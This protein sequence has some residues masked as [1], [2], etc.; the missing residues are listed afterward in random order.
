MLTFLSPTI[1]KSWLKS[2]FPLPHS[3]PLFSCS[4][5]LEI[6]V[7]KEWQPSCVYFMQVFS[8]SFW[9]CN[10]LKK[11]M[12][13]L[14]NKYIF[15]KIV[16]WVPLRNTWWK[17]S[18]SHQSVVQLEP[19]RGLWRWLIRPLHLNHCTILRF[20]KVCPTKKI[21]TCYVTNYMEEFPHLLTLQ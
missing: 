18:A 10:G 13:I 8:S 6:R 16:R 20:C 12:T 11:P 1:T 5:I 19:T 9:R 7:I 21:V 3:L 4:I 2:L 14:R 15:S 17:K